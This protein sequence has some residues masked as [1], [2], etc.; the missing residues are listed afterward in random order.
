MNYDKIKEKAEEMDVDT[1]WAVNCRIRYVQWVITIIREELAYCNE[2]INYLI[3]LLPGAGAFDRQWSLELIE[4]WEKEKKKVKA[5]YISS[6]NTTKNSDSV[7]DEMI[8]QAKT[9]NWELIVGTLYHNKKIICPFHDDKN[10][11]FYIASGFGYC[12]SCNTASDQIKYIQKV[13]GFAFQE[14]VRFLT[15]L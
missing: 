14:A 3:R 13:K 15:N 10:P 9:V 1:K 5:I 6:R 8:E 2:Q 12:F 11:S 7:T 4:Y